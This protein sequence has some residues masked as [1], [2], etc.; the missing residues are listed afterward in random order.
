MNDRQRTALSE[1]L[2]RIGSWTS[3]RWDQHLRYEVGDVDAD[4]IIR[5]LN[6]QG[7]YPYIPESK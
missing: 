6:A 7:V 2:T 3:A 1:L 5:W 4:A